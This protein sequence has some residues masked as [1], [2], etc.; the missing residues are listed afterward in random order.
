[1]SARRQQASESSSSSDSGQRAKAL[2]L[3]ES[4]LR[5][6]AESNSASTLDSKR[7]DSC[8]KI[9]TTLLLRSRH[10]LDITQ[11]RAA[12]LVETHPISLGR[13]ERG[14]VDLGPLRDWVLMLREMVRARGPEGASAFKAAFIETLAERDSKK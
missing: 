12:A 11:E 1:M 10:E 2:G 7:T 14:Q 5:E 4:N 13:R 6:R 3:H 9:A 8:H